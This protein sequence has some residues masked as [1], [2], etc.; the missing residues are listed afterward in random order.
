MPTPEHMQETVD[1]YLAGLLRIGHI[2]TGGRGGVPAANRDHP[3]RGAP[4]ATM[5]EGKFYA[6]GFETTPA[7]LLSFAALSHSLNL[8]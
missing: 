8:P 1:N 6:T 7:F 3:P 4:P 2:R 5:C